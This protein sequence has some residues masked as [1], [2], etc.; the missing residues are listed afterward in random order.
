MKCGIYKILNLKNNKVYIGSSKNIF[1]R[2]KEHKKSLRKGSHHNQHLQNSYNKH[3]CFSFQY[4]IEEECNESELLVKEELHLS[5]YKNHYNIAEVA[6]NSPTPKTYEILDETGK[7]I[8][9]KNAREFCKKHKLS[10]GNFSQMASGKREQC[11]PYR[12]TKYNKK[13][14]GKVVTFT[15]GKETIT[16]NVHK[17]AKQQNLPFQNLYKVANGERASC[18]GWFLLDS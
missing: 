9:V 18:G 2:W 3:G 16:Q 12:S 5:K 14:K 10:P 6:R 17:F 1:S 7:V 4:I 8:K 11:G 15:N 13:A